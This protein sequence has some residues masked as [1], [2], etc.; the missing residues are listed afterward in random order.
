MGNGCFKSDASRSGGQLEDVF[1]KDAYMAYYHGAKFRGAPSSKR[2][3]GRVIVRQ[4]QTGEETASEIASTN[5]SVYTPPGAT[6]IQ[7]IPSSVAPL[8]AMDKV[9]TYDMCP[10][11]LEGPSSLLRTV[12]TDPSGE[13]GSFV[14]I[15]VET[16]MV[17]VSVI[18]S[19]KTNYVVCTPDGRHV[20]R[21]KKSSRKHYVMEDL[22]YR[23][24]YSE[25]QHHSR[26]LI[27]GPPVS[28]GPVC[29]SIENNSKVIVGDSPTDSH[30]EGGVDML[31]VFL[32][33]AINIIDNK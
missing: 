31:V 16:G 6:T 13:Q 26:L 22:G 7:S 8:I 24:S 1:D 21:L 3:T 20:T 2:R 23:A 17:L 5:G 12:F 33:N 9:I 4:P 10:F 11:E 32:F 19:N 18:C 25:Q 29:C 30:H 14:V 27:T 28:G 15:D